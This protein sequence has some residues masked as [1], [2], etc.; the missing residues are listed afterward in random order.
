MVLITMA[1]SQSQVLRLLSSL[2]SHVLPVH[3]ARHV[4]EKSLTLSVHVPSFLQGFGMQSL[5][6]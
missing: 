3:G 2:R 6:S 5:T 4:Q 1:I